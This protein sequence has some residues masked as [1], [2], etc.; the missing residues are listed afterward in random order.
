M[1]VKIKLEKQAILPRLDSVYIIDPELWE[2]S[3]SRDANIISQ[4]SSNFYTTRD[5]QFLVWIFHFFLN[6]KAN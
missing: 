5:S 2:K 4:A 3:K 1:P 6:I